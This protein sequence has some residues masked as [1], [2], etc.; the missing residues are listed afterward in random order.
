MLSKRLPMLVLTLVGTATMAWSQSA[1]TAALTGVVKESSGKPVSG[2]RMH[3]SSPSLIRGTLSF[4]LSENG[5]YHFSSLPPGRYRIDVEAEGY[6]TMG[7]EATLDL[8]RTT[9]LNWTLTPRTGTVVEVISFSSVFE[10]VPGG[11]TANFKVSNLDTLPVSRSL[12]AILNLTPGINANRAWGGMETNNAFLMDGVNVGDPAGNAQWIFPNMDWFEEVHVGGIGAP[13]E[14][15]NFTGGYLNTL[16]KRGGNTVTGGLN[17]FYRTTDWQA[18]LNNEDPRLTESA[19]T[20]TPAKD[21]EAGFHVGGPIQKDR[22]WY[23]VSASRTQ[24][25]DHPIGA[26]QSIQVRNVRMLT[27]LTWQ[28]SENG[29]LEGFFQ[30]DTMDGDN[31]DLNRYQLPVATVRQASPN[32]SYNLTYTHRIGSDKV[33]TVKGMGYAGRVDLLAYNGQSPALQVENLY[34]GISGYNNSSYES[35]NDRRRGTLAGTLDWFLTSGKS[36][37]AL[38]MGFE[39]ERAEDKERL[40][41]PGGAVLYASTV[42]GKLMPFMAMTGGGR[43]FQATLGRTAAFIQDT[44]TLTDQLVLTPGLRW[45][46]YTGKDQAGRSHWDSNTVAP[47]LGATLMLTGNQAHVFKAHAGR[48]YEGLNAGMFSRSIPGAWTMEQYYSWGNGNP[49]DPLSPASWPSFNAAASTPWLQI[50]QSS[51]LASDI[52]HPYA[53][54][55]SFA[56][57]TLFAKVWTASLTWISKQNHD[58][59]VRLDRASDP[60]GSFQ[61]LVNPLT[62]QPV[63]FWNTGLRGNQHQYEIANDARSKRDYQALTIAVERQMENAWSLAASYTRATLKGNITRIDG[64]DDVFLSTNSLIQANGDLPG[65]HD[66]ELKAR[67]VLQ[68]PTHTQVAATFTYLSGA[69]WTPVLRTPW[70]GPDQA[71]YAEI[72]AAPRGAETLPDRKLLDIR[73][74]QTA[75]LTKQV[76]VE[77][78]LEIR[79]ALNE[80]AAT[81]TERRVN[82]NTIGGFNPWYK[83]LLASETPRNLR[84]GLR[85]KF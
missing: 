14:Y 24:S 22:V 50:D 16:I 29:T 15:G 75:N 10:P 60:N 64:L 71:S 52:R 57:E 12:D 39:Q 33:V 30:Y 72:N 76:Q 70:L 2:A 73:I 7:G 69:H 37:H 17:G 41:R 84:L 67:G 62:G 81:A 54:A 79:N 58:A 47:R 61:S 44:W 51:R 26:A 53:D 25:E 78:Y 35:W 66:Q 34:N 46:H 38:R 80:G 18:K 85:L 83:V 49:I 40:A 8:G 20:T 11:V 5:V 13:A 21:W 43:D 6:E 74:S 4:Q 3:I 42:Q 48:Y 65:N 63:N 56:Y 31:R 77:A 1:T 59:V 45:E 36:S 27:K 9:T 28:A 68:L 82:V 55:Y 19:K 23:F 32:R